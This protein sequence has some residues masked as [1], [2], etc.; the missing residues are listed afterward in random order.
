MSSFHEFQAEFDLVAAELGRAIRGKPHVIRLCLIALFAEGHILLD[1]VPGVGKTTLAKSLAAVFGGDA[2]RIQFTPDLLPTDILGYTA[3]RD[4]REWFEPGPVFANVVIADEINRVSPKTQAALL[5]AMEERQVTV[6]GRTNDLPD[7]FIVI[8]TENPIEFE[9]VY[10]LPEAQLDRFLIRTRIG[11]PDIAT[12]AELI[13]LYTSPVAIPERA[14][15]LR[16]SPERVRYLIDLV[17]HV[18]VSS[19]IYDYVARLAAAT[20]ELPAE[21]RLGVSPRGSIALV[22]AA[23][24]AAAAAGRGEVLPEDVEELVVPVLAHRMILTPETELE[25]TAAAEILE[26]VTS[27]LSVFAGGR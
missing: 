7:P 14:V 16:L 15:T 11:T 17:A 2:K 18:H 4:G 13:R 6:H 8:A 21:V 25:G 5:Q 27:S 3:W 19:R 9:G 10:R 1:D 22:R 20:R 23:R 26:R 12:E 24:V